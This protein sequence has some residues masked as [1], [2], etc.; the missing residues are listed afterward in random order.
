[1]DAPNHLDIRALLPCPF[2]GGEAAIGTVRWKASLYRD[3]MPDLNRTEGFF[4]QC[5]RCPTEQKLMG[6]GSAT[7]EEAAAKWNRR[8]HAPQGA[9]PARGMMEAAFRAGYD[10]GYDDG[11]DRAGTFFSVKERDP[12]AAWRAFRLMQAPSQGSPQEV[13]AL[14]LEAIEAR[15][16]K[17]AKR[18]E[19][20]TAFDDLTRHTKWFAACAT[21]DIPALIAEVR[22][23][24]AAIGRP[25]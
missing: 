1:M 13:E 9:A 18:L 23:L 11:S 19:T 3:C 7:R 25:A 5:I 22:R 6:V 2:C 14:D 10:S 24:R 4:G 20:T 15:A 12:G 17:F 16:K 21:T 8:A